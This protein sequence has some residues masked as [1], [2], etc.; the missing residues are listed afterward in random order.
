MCTA[1]K[2]KFGHP[3][4]NCDCTSVADFEGETCEDITGRKHPS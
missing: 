4:V 1:G 2:N 3:K